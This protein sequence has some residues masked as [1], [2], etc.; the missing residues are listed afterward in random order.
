[1]RSARAEDFFSS[2]MCSNNRFRWALAVLLTLGLQWPAGA[3]VMLGGTR[4]ILGEKDREASIPV[5]NTGVSPYVV[6]SWIDAG[7]GRN[8]TPLL[9]TPPLSRLDPGMENILRIMRTTGELPSDRESVFWLNVK[10]IPEKSRDENVLQIAVRSRIKVF[11]RPSGLQGKSDQSR[12]QL[13]WA[14]SAGAQGQG[15]VL[16]IANPTG[17]HVTFTA[18]NVN[19]G[20]QL[21]N[22][23]MVP[24]FGEVAYPLSAVK[25]PQA[26][27][28]GYTTLNDYGG[29]TPEERVQVPAGAEPVAVTVETVTP[30]PADG[31]K[32]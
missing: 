29:E 7:E 23:D 2:L 30:P 16:K 12:G 17:Y 10:E 32:R 13:R 22:A 14:V 1:M 4:V 24:P 11:Y 19:N 20:Q 3:G 28:V 25:A 8:K 26:V 15:A 21:I 6:Q 18:L 27:Q 31:A 9:V 5:K